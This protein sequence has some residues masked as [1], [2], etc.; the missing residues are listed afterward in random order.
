ML[1]VDPSHHQKT[2]RTRLM[3]AV[4]DICTEEGVKSLW[5]M[6]YDRNVPALGLYKKSGYVVKGD[7][8]F[9]ERIDGENSLVLV[10]SIRRQASV[11][12]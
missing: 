2:V 4:D 6:A 9:G 5:L 10:K 7:T 11:A 3:Q 8:G 12:I 1:Y